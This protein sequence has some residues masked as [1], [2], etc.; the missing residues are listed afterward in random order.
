MAVSS[1]VSWLLRYSMTFASPRMSLLRLVGYFGLDRDGPAVAC[2]VVDP[3]V[4]T[5]FDQG[6][7]ARDARAAAGAGSAGGADRVVVGGAGV[8]VRGHLVGGDREA[9]ADVHET[10]RRT[11]GQSVR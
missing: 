5:G 11:S 6:A 9:D 7:R 8:D 2:P 3:G 1:A 10:L 4:D